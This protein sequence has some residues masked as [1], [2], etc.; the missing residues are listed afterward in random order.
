MQRP[1]YLLALFIGL[2]IMGCE[3][4]INPEDKMEAEIDGKSFEAL[5]VKGVEE[6]KLI[7]IT[8]TAG[9]ENLVVA[10]NSD[11]TAGTY[12]MRSGKAYTTFTDGSKSYTLTTSG[13]V[14][15]EEHDTE[16]HFVKGTFNGVMGSE[17]DS[18]ST[19]SVKSGTFQA[20]YT[21]I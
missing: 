3:G 9:L 5:A 10:M 21:P 13:S 15:I 11:I 19:T 14:T 17:L 7:L 6:S 18:S 16:E 1:F 12:D 20:T 2:S 8:G 4:L